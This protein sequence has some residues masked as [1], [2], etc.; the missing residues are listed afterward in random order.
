VSDPAL[1]RDD[2]IHFTEQGY[3]RLGISLLRAI[4]QNLRHGAPLP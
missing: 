3:R 1:E 2:R 4:G